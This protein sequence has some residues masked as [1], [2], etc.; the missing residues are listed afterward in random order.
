MH[1]S[2]CWSAE[3]TVTYCKNTASARFFLC[4]SVFFQFSYIPNPY[5]SGFLLCSM[6]ALLLAQTR[7]HFFDVAKKPLL[8]EI[9]YDILTRADPKSLQKKWLFF[10]TGSRREVAPGRPRRPKSTVFSK[11]SS[12]KEVGGGCMG[13]AKERR[14]SLPPLFLSRTWN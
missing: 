13:E 14:I 5:T 1:F 4:L 7:K 9:T 10:R 12:R 3:S 6:V 2:I 8:S 11:D